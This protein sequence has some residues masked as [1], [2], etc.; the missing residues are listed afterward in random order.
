MSACAAPVRDSASVGHARGGGERK[1]RTR[2]GPVLL[3]RKHN[4]GRAHLLGVRDLVLLVSE[5]GDFGAHS[6]TEEDGEVA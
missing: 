2:L 6:D 1:G 5:D 4:V 3:S